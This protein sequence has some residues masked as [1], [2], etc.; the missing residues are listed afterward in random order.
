MYRVQVP[1]LSVNDLRAL[2]GFAAPYRATLAAG[3]A[4][5]LLESAAALAVPW[6]GGRIAA[7]LLASGPAG[8]G[9]MTL[10]LWAML[11]LFALQA[12][13]RFAS[14]SVLGAA[15][16]RIVADLKIRAYDH[17]QALPLAFFQERRA[18]DTLALLTYDVYVV[19]GYLTGT[20]LAIVPLLVTGAGAAALMFR[21][22]AP[23][24]LATVLLIP[25]FFLMVKILG[26]K[27]RPLA[28]QLQQEHATG[29]AIAEE[30]LGML[31]AIKA[32]TREE[33][34]SQRH[35]QQMDLIRRLETRQ[36][37]I[38]AA[39]GPAVQF[40]AAAG[41]VGLLWLASGEV[42]GGKLTPAK[43]IEFLLY[44]QL[45]ARP[46][47]GLADIYGQ[48]QTTRGA[49]RRLMHALDEEPEPPPNVGT[50]L[51]K[52]RGEIRFEDVSFGYPGRPPALQG[53]HLHVAAGETVAITG[54]N[55]AGKSTLSHLLARLHKPGEGRIT[56]DGADIATVSLASL[57]SQIGIVPQ[58]VLLFNATVRENIAYGRVDATD[59]QIE[60][61]ARAAR[62]HDF[63]GGLP[64]GY[65]T[66]IGD[67]GVR[68]SG[69]QRQ[70]IALARALLK[71]PPI[72]ILDEATAMFDPEGE[73]EF[74]EA[75]RDLMAS[76]TVLLITHR[77]APLAMAGR[78]I[79]L[80][81]GRVVD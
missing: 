1:F 76:R 39:M 33:E 28:Q 47:A 31:P 24:A 59:A 77:P 65:D 80:E 55:G 37:R 10:V 18:G 75:C 5:M 68:L 7:T 46:V 48:T 12:L 41:I 81:G 50:V 64:A 15:S 23:L 74:L 61:A 29:V 67:Q 57:R 9:S 16:Q 17:L 72:L 3:A 66:V 42:A 4:M 26:R 73:R 53:L 62:A 19:S 6:L 69:G 52:V 13:L 44:A 35:G 32:F 78:T 70:R 11:A 21:I 8:G 34:E 71:D 79:R 22:Q 36:L 27:L 20:A 63:I 14:A 58:H 54:P 43:L 49:M 30:N 45:L 60:A 25:V 56:I 40:V 51:P 2:L 38:H